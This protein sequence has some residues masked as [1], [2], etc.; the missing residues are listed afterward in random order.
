[1]GTRNVLDVMKEIR[2]E[3]TPDVWDPLFGNTTMWGAVGTRH[4]NMWLAHN[5]A[6]GQWPGAQM[7][8]KRESEEHDRKKT[9]KATTINNLPAHIMHIVESADNERD[10]MVALKALEKMGFEA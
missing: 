2:Q 9:L 6:F 5:A 8:R 7:Q 1:M 3:V 10:L 4:I